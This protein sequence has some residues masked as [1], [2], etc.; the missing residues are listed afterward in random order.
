MFFRCAHYHVQSET[1]CEGHKNRCIYIF[2]SVLIEMEFKTHSSKFPIINFD[3]IVSNGKA[4]LKRHGDLLPNTIRAVFCGP[5]N[6][7]KTNVLLSLIAHEKGLQFS[8]IYVYSK[9]LNQPKYQFLEKVI[10]P[11]EGINYFPFSD[12]EQ[13]VSVDDAKPDSIFIFDDVACEKQNHIKSYFC[14]GRHKNIDSVYLCQSYTRIPKHLVRDNMNFL[15]LFKQDE[16]NLKHIYNDHVNT[17][18]SYDCFKKICLACWNDNYG[19]MVIDKD[20]EIDGGRYRKN[21]D[22]FISINKEV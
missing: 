3:S 7:G 21:L 13:V 11:L 4:T 22:T 5:S 8:N 2:T 9:S 15:I 14:M 17:D 16:M 19:F 18:M 12:N 1:D 6:C 20:S 10:E